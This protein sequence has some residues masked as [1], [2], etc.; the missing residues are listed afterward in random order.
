LQGNAFKD[1]GASYLAFMLRFNTHLTELN[2]GNN[3]LGDDGSKSI[4]YAL[5]YNNTLQALHLNAN[6]LSSAITPSMGQLLK[7]NTSLLTLDLS[8]NSLGDT[9]A[10]YLAA[11]LKANTSLRR[12]LLTQCEIGSRGAQALASALRS[13][14]TLLELMLAHNPLDDLGLDALAQSLRYNQ[15]LRIIDVTDTGITLQGLSTIEK[16]LA[17]NP[18]LAVL[19]VIDYA[20]VSTER[21]KL[22]NLYDTVSERAHNY[23]KHKFE[24]QA[25]ETQTARYK[26]TQK[27]ACLLL[28]AARLYIQA[29]QSP[30]SLLY[31]LPVELQ[32]YIVSTIDSKAL[33]N[34]I[35]HRNIWHY[36]AQ[37]PQREASKDNFLRY[38]F[39]HK[40]SIKPL[41]LPQTD[42]LTAA[43]STKEADRSTRKRSE[44]E[45]PREA[46]GLG[47][48]P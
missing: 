18:Q 14:S 44:C 7:N 32:E 47:V 25:Q 8:Y 2:L 4:A 9:G 16:L 48:F 13:N 5:L 46:V 12:L 19:F 39:F 23:S 27:I 42:L 20:F 35:Q 17:Q 6:F 37:R 29:R 22:I 24:R 38:T 45:E 3:K 10:V 36:A 34:P 43:S 21:N 11:G 1:I 26:D 28:N 30:E 15:A 31:C 41:E 40:K 33:L